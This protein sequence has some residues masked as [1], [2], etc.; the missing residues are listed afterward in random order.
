MKIGRIECFA[1]ISGDMLLGAL[2]DAGVPPELLRQAAASL[3]I[4][5]EL[6]IHSVDR[7]GIQ[8]TKVDVLE[9][10]VPAQGEENHGHHH[11]GEHSHR[12]ER[13]SDHEHT[14]SRNWPQIRALISGA[15]LPAATKKIA[16][17][18]FQLLAE[19]E[20]KV[21]GIAPEQ[22]H[23]HEVGAVDTITDIVCAA[24]GLDAL[25]RARGGSARR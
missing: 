25:R 2:V 24:A 6:R 3:K 20:A 16:L 1:G 15:E 22:V 11:E 13:P 14:H 9:H 8:A 4:G 12:H 17:R 23:F 19:A 10:G 5:A 18:A 7:G 21:H